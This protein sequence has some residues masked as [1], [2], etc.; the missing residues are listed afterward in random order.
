[1]E[2]TFHVLWQCKDAQDIWGMGPVIFQKRFYEGPYFMQVVEGM[3][4]ICD[5]Q[6]FKLFVGITRRIWKRRNAYVHE[7]SFVHPSSILEQAR[8]ELGAYEHAQGKDR[9]SESLTAPVEEQPNQKW[10]APPHGWVK[11]NWDA[12]VEKKTGRLGVGIIIRDDREECCA[13]KSWMRM[14]LLDPTA[15]EAMAAF[16]AVQMCTALGMQQVCFE[17]DARVVVDAVNRGESSENHWGH[18]VAD[19]L[20]GLRGI[21]H[22][23]MRY[24]PQGVNR[25]AHILA[26]MATATGTNNEWFGAFPE[27]IQT[28]IAAE[29]CA[30][31]PSNY[32]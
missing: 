31:I 6:E 14:G 18:L 26:K 11:A 4:K 10:K 23:K 17:G 27:C 16:L 20:I 32:Y 2:S 7:G 29:R 13:A 28:I 3:S 8:E 15:V 12:A 25:G 5:T 9:E 19:I 22:W 24:V 21:H 1:V 30:L